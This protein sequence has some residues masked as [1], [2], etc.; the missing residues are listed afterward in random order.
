MPAN[1]D[2]IGKTYPATTYAVGREKVREYAH[3]VGETNPLYLNVDHAR[4]AGYADVVAPPMFAVVFAG[5]AITPALF[6]P[7]V[8][9]D[10]ARMLHGGQEFIWGP[11]VVAG[12]EIVT[13]TTVKD[14]SERGGMSFFVF[15]TDSRNQRGETVCTGMWTNLVRND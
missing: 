3:A 4:D 15:E 13:T 7:E 12:D 14:I 10:F 1:T 6:D 9:I 11:V 8:G 2:A 5:R